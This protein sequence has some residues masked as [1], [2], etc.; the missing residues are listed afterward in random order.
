MAKSA[1]E[2]AQAHEVTSSTLW[3]V[4]QNFMEELNLVFKFF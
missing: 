2:L 4:I 1:K 3:F